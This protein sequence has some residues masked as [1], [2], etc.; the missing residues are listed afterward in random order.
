MYN[1]FEPA[2]PSTATISTS[3]FRHRLAHYIGLVRYG[4][5]V[6]VIQRKGEEPVYLISQ[7][8]WDLLGKKIDHL[9]NDGRDPDTGKLK[10]GLWRLLRISYG[11]DSI[12]RSREQVVPRS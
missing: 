8:D 7:A 5:D 10:L 3:E 4:N 11:A 9:E 2:D 12:W 6:V 1:S